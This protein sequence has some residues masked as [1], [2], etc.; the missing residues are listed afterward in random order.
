MRRF[1]ASTL[2]GCAISTLSTSAE[3]AAEKALPLRTVVDVRLTGGSSRLDYESL[4][5]KRTLLFIAHLGASEVIVVDTKANRV[6]KTISDLSKVHGVLAVPELNRVYASATGTNEVAVIDESSLKVIARVP[7]GT[8]PDGMA[9][10]PDRH[11]L[12]VSDEHGGADTVI[13]TDT[14][15]RIATVALGGDV[16]N[17]QYD[18]RTHRIFVNVQTKGDLVAIDPSTNGVV[19]R[20]PISG[21]KSNHGLLI[22]DAHRLAY[23]ACEENATLVVFDL[24]KLAQTQTVPIGPDPDVLGYDRGRSTLYVACESGT[25]TMLAARKDGLHK[26]AEAFVAENAHVVAVDDRTHRLYFPLL[27]PGGTPLLRVMEPTEP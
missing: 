17:T 25:V 9:F 16:G 20:Y 4:D 5:P 15:R 11:K 24:R 3:L 14:N 7:A 22:D 26:L 12:Y 21:C 13:D 6:V 1:V 23:I 10:V 2:V 18:A 27:E 8:Y 19:A